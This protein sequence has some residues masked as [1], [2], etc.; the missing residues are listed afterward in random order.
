[1]IRTGSLTVF[2][3]WLTLTATADAQAPAWRFRW[4]PGQVL[5]YHVEHTMTATDTV[6]GAKAEMV[7]KLNEIKRWQVL[8]VDATGVALLQLTVPSLRFETKTHK[9]DVLL[10]DSANLDKSTPD[11]RDQLLKYLNT[12]LATLRVD[13]SGKVLE[14]KECKQG[15]GTRYESEPPF[16]VVLPPA[17]AQ[18]GQT[19]ERAYN[20]TLEPPQGTGEKLPAVQKYTC[21]AVD[22][23]DATL[24]LTTTLQ[25]MPDAAAD[26]VPLV[27]FLHDGEIVFD[28]QAGLLRSAR[29]VVD[30]EV[31]GHQGEG[32]TYH[33]RSTYTEEYVGAN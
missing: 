18:V 7:N 20:I 15:T 10:F 31:A 22:A 32:S 12:P 1:M 13:A 9:G 25:K 24:T 6:D 5:S 3:A 4:Q 30:K 28:P 21:K 19:W 17:A 11:L 14:V 16:V 2:V 27:Q 23:K 8:S 26:R 29:L 33:F